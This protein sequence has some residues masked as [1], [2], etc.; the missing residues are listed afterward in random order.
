MFLGHFAVAFAAKRAAP[1]LSLGTLFLAAQLADLVW[2]ALVSLGVESFEV[3]P[4][5]TA[6]T[7]LDFTYYPWSHSLTAMAFWGVA[8]AVAWV[9]VRQGT[10]KAALVILAV[11]LSHWLLDW[12][13]HRPD[14]P[15]TV[16][17]ESKHGLGLWSSLPATLAVEG[18]LFALGVA[19]YAR[20]TSPRD[21]IGRW[22]FR[23]LVVFLVG[24]YLANLF[25][26]PP[27][28]EQA[29]AWSAYAI[30]LLVA[31][32]YWVDRHRLPRGNRPAT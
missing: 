21:R 27:P 11:V 8:L 1:E 4:G 28:N 2:P 25:G 29:V 16:G 14:L 22:A 3:R 19:I 23:A 24:A 15:L 5:A 13:S 7:P 6:V 32:G 30:W 12:I 20:M 10:P 9:A 31:W 17:G 18:A 26:P